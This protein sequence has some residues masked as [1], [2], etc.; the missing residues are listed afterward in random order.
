MSADQSTPRGFSSFCL[1]RRTTLHRP[2][3]RHQISSNTVRLILAFP[4]TTS[5]AD[6]RRGGLPTVA[7]PPPLSWALPLYPEIRGSVSFRFQTSALTQLGREGGGG[8]VLQS[9]PPPS[10]RS[11]PAGQ[12]PASRRLSFRVTAV[13]TARAARAPGRGGGGAAPGGGGEARSRRAGS[14]PRLPQAL[15]KSTG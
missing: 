8:E 7:P 15:G 1:L 3:R 5:H 14:P 13:Q 4:E 6:F 10:G 9:P 2:F 12:L 11:Q